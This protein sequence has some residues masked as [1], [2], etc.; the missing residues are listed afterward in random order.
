[1]KEKVTFETNV[2]VL[3][4]LAQLE[5]MEVQGRCGDEVMYNLQDGRVMFVPLSLRDEISKL[6]V[7]PGEPLQ[8]CKR[9]VVVVGEPCIEWT[10]SRKESS[11]SPKAVQVVQTKLE[12]A[13][14]MVTGCSKLSNHTG[15]QL[16]CAGGEVV[17]IFDTGRVSV[18]GKNDARVRS[19]LGLETSRGEQTAVTQTTS[20]TNDG[21]ASQAGNGDQA[22]KKNGAPKLSYVMQMALQG[23]LDATKAV[24][25]Y[26]ED[27]GIIDRNGDPFRFTNADIRAIGLSMFIEARKRAW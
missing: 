21:Q 5:G 26:A 1:M 3:V 19:I 15:W 2:P 7:K 13:G 16:C 24:E 4:A 9:E 10:V 17:N 25:K 6:E 22:N 27:S 23:A 20:T 11:Q 8:V 12:A 14:L 18:Q